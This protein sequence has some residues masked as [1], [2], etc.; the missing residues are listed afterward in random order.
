MTSPHDERRPMEAQRDLLSVTTAAQLTGL[1]RSI[2]SNWITRGILPAV[3]IAGRR[4]VQVEDLLSTHAT[5]HGRGVV[6]AWRQDPIH[7]GRRLRM[8]REAAGLTQIHLAVA[9][10]LTHEA[11]SRLETGR[12]APY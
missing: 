4:Y 11:I 10:G 1:S 6:P 9:S 3:R 7:A 2:I 12:Y 8:I 5:V